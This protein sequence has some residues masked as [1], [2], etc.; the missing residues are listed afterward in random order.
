VIGVDVDMGRGTLA[1]WVDGKFLTTVARGL[2]GKTLYPAFS[3]FSDSI[4]DI[5]TGIEV[6]SL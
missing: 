2:S 4:M 5:K 3:I 6:P 1:F